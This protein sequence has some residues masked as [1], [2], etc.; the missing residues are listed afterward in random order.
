MGWI[1]GYVVASHQNKSGSI[2]V[3][4]ISHIYYVLT[5]TQNLDSCGVT[6]LDL[7]DIIVEHLS[8]VVKVKATTNLELVLKG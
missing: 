1:G 3:E 7:D 8:D 6:S 5:F 2:P 4:N